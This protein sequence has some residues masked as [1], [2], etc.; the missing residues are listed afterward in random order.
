MLVQ[1]RT[2]P[3]AVC[4]AGKLQ[5]IFYVPSHTQSG[6]IRNLRVSLANR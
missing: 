5:P 3:D 1:L 6:Y 4:F 2:V